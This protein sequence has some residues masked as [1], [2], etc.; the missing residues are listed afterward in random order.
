METPETSRRGSRKVHEGVEVP[1][2]SRSGSLG[3]TKEWRCRR[4]LGV[5]LGSSGGRG[6]YLY[7]VVICQ[8]GLC[9]D[10]D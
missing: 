1:E 8:E 6:E 3:S 9:L 10:L 4:R 7:T 5:G 2:T